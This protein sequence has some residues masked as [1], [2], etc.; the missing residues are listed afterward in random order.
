MAKVEVIVEDTDAEWEPGSVREAPHKLFLAGVGAWAMAQDAMED[1]V[2]RL[3]ERGERVE[4]AGKRLLGERLDRRRNQVRRI[5][6]R[7]K[8]EILD[9]EEDFQAW[10][11]ERLDHMSVPTKDDLD[12]LSA[13]IA[14]LSKKVD[15]LKEARTS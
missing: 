13:K 1:L 15:E 12:A 11:A 6:R 9:A 14:E 7:E 3:V 5:V 2:C 8:E 4:K 10:I